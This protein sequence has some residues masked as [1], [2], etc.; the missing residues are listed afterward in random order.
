MDLCKI[1]QKVSRIKKLSTLGAKK[2]NSCEKRM[3]R[4]NGMEDRPQ[5]FRKTKVLYLVMFK[6]QT[7]LCHA[8]HLKKSLLLQLEMRYENQT[9][10]LIF[11]TPTLKNNTTQ[12]RT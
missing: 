7:L 5:Y 4:R 1:K 9:C 3:W 2:I 11:T 10:S 12:T 8:D 6:G